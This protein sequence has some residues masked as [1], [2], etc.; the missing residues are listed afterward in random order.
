MMC[1]GASEAKPADDETHQICAAVKGELE[2]KVGKTFP[3]YTALLV[4][5]QVV[6][7]TNFFV[8]I[9]VGSGDHVHARIFRPLP[10]QGN[11]PSVHSHQTGKTADDALEY[12]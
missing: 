10:H 6:A 7:G 5:K 8:K 12:F 2:G 11:E 9:H 1:G 4:R 3:E